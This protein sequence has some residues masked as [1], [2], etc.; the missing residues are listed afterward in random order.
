MH[1][2]LNALR[3]ARPDA[4]VTQK[5]FFVLEIE[6]YLPAELY[7]HLL[8]TYPD[9]SVGGQHYSMKNYFKSGTPAFEGFLASS[10]E[11]ARLIRYMDSDEFLAHIFDYA[12]PM[13]REARGKLG[14]RRWTRKGKPVDGGPSVSSSGA[15]KLIDMLRFTEI[16]TG[17]ELSAMEN[18]HCI[19]AHSD[20]TNKLVSVLLYFPFPDWQPQW[21]GGTQF[22]R[23]KTLTAERRWCHPGVNHIKDFGP[24]GLKQFAEEM[25][26]FHT[27]PFAPNYFTMFCKSTNTFHAVD[28][29]AC[30]PDRRR[31]CLV[32][33]VYAKEPDSALVRKGVELVRKGK[34]WVRT[35]GGQQ[36]RPVSSGGGYD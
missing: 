13:I 30:P 10:P 19:T 18:G 21:G 17:F 1:L 22:F 5:P 2:D 9:P 24:A 32:F 16:E 34:T 14:T 12:R 36:L 26:C 25:E 3:L 20:A 6:N 31:N 11:W 33:N 29:I 8:Q 27:A 28:T 15:S 35:R 4:R 7:A 23:P